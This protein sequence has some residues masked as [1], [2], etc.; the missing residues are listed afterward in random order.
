MPPRPQKSS[1]RGRTGR[2]PIACALSLWLAGCGAAP[3]SEEH[4]PP[5]PPPLQTVEQDA[6]FIVDWDPRQI[7]SLTTA[8]RTPNAGGV[9]V[10]Y[11]RNV[12]RLLPDCHL[13]GAYVPSGI[14]MYRGILQVRRFDSPP[15]TATTRQDALQQ[16]STSTNV[17]PG[18][19]LESR[20]VIVGRHYL[21]G[22]RPNATVKD[23]TSRT[24]DGC[25]DATHF[26]R[27]ALTGAFEHTGAGGP[28]VPGA[29]PAP[30][31]ATLPRGGDFTPCVMAGNAG[32][33]A[34]SAFLKIELTP[35]LPA[36][37]TP[38]PPPTPTATATTTPTAAPP[39][40]APQILSPKGPA[41]QATAT[42]TAAPPAT[43][44][45]PQIAIPKPPPAQPTTPATQPTTP[46]ATQPTTP[47]PAPQ[48][49]ALP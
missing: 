10:A 36:P 8:L 25:R 1:V 40:T 12:I 7:A 26:G 48:P 23:L 47:P 44:T 24:A 29:P 35:V 13:A 33:P 6:P 31:P 11:Q 45:A 37:T 41:P 46:P 43:A 32:T 2:H 4:R 20:F 19:L 21:S 15:R 28:A 39:A 34:C 49:P 22:N 16:I 42:P 14:G 38:E 17:P 3:P 30:A 18:A 5:E 27:A 9:V